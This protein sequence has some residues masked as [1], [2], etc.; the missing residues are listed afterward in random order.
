MNLLPVFRVQTACLEF[1][2]H[3]KSPD[4][5][6]RVQTASTTPT[7]RMC[8]TVYNVGCACFM[9]VLILFTLFNTQH[10]YREY[11]TKQTNYT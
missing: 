6:F 7:I 10:L 9:W 2:R 11:T 4:D 8:E 3:V 5:M 1:R